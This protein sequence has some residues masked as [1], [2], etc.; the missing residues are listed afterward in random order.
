MSKDAR[1]SNKSDAS[2]AYLQGMSIICWDHR[3]FCSTSLRML[4]FERKQLIMTTSTSL[5]PE[6]RLISLLCLPRSAPHRL[7]NLG[8]PTGQNKTATNISNFP[9]SENASL[10]CT[11]DGKGAG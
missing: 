7:W 8:I 6:R 1:H 10:L 5:P 4:Q 2:H 9:S 11:P 3:G